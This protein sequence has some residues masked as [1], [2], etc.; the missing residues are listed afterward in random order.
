M[1]RVASQFLS[2]VVKVAPGLGLVEKAVM[3]NF[4]RTHYGD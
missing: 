4:Q 3:G 2:E 1:H